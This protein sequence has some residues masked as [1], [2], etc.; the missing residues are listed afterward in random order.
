MLIVL[1]EK[2]LNIQGLNLL[3]EGG[4]INLEH[5][6]DSMDCFLKADDV[7]FLNFNNRSVQILK[8]RNFTG[9]NVMKDLLEIYKKYNL[10]Y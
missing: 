4:S 2:D 10:L 5:I 9:T 8:S 1:T 6:K 7:L 3:Q